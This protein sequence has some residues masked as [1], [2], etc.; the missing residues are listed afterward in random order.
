MTVPA[1]TPFPIGRVAPFRAVASLVA[2]IALVLTMAFTPDV[3]AAEP[4]PAGSGSNATQ[5]SVTGG[6]ATTPP[7]SSDNPTTEQSAPPTDTGGPASTEGGSPSTDGRSASTEPSTES[8][9]EPTAPSAKP[10]VSLNA[11]AVLGAPNPLAALQGFGALVRGSATLDG[12]VDGS[13]AIGGDAA[14]GDYALSPGAA[15]A[16]IDGASI[17]LLTG[18]TVTGRDNAAQVTVGGGNALLGD[19]GTSTPRSIDG[20]LGLFRPDSDQPLVQV[21]GGQGA[22]RVRAPDLFAQAFGG[23]LDDLTARGKVLATLP[24]TVRPADGEGA[25]LTSFDGADMQLHLVDGVNVWTVPAA[26]LAAA[27]SISVDP[28][29][30]PDS[31]LVINV[32][33]DTVTLGAKGMPGS[34]A[35]A[36]LWNVPDAS[37]VDV[38]APLAGSLLA[39]S[40]T[41]T[42]GAS[43]RGTLVADSVSQLAGTTLSAVPFA[44][45]L[46]TSTSTPTG[47]QPG[48]P[49]MQSTGMR[50]V[51]IVSET[52]GCA[53]SGPWSGFGSP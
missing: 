35:E 26:D 3:V 51:R 19:L 5:S 25:P 30:T 14:V 42:I 15:A 33:G 39:P 36:V 31:P 53:S 29:P 23:V 17:G 24:A 43:V 28:A 1:R 48:E 8:T 11:R 4:D 50:R 7:T 32:T 52:V 18:G 46:P 40:S 12:A 37:T 10:A 47:E 20:G 9:P 6:S 22:D 45:E 34:A 41:V 2:V 49:T 13:I 38:T 16:T 21:A 44:A 27:H